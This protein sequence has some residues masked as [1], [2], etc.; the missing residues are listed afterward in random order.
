MKNFLEVMSKNLI[1]A[2]FFDK[3]CM[4]QS[5]LDEQPYQSYASY[6]IVLG[7][8]Q[9]RDV[10]KYYYHRELFEK[11]KMHHERKGAKAAE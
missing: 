10:P 6:F 3:S 11:G 2:E 7:Q 9:D 5:N 4:L 8:K 1:N